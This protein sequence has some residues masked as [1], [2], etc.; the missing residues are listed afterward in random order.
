M[1]KAVLV[2][3]AALS[4]PAFAGT[5]SDPAQ[6]APRPAPGVRLAQNCD[7]YASMLCSRSAGEAQ[8]WSRNN[9]VG[10]VV[11]TSSNDY[12][13]F[14]AG[15]FCVVEGPM[16]QGRA[17]ATANSYRGISPQAYVKNSC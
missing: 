15:Y 4:V 7:W 14:A 6:T 5:E 8:R 1:F 12:P 9:G 2:A 17:Q 11:N 16:S 3:L 13:N 10:Y